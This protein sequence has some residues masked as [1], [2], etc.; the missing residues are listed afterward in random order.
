MIS[1]IVFLD[2]RKWFFDIKKSSFFISRIIFWYKKLF[3]DIKNRI[4]DIKK[5]FSDV[6]KYLK[7]IKTVPHTYLSCVCVFFGNIPGIFAESN[8]DFRYDDTRCWSEVMYT[9]VY[10]MVY[11]TR[12]AWT[13]ASFF[14]SDTWMMTLNFMYIHCIWQTKIELKK[15]NKFSRLWITL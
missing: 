11:T 9:M 10:T 1:N 14:S 13:T 3:F 7:N 6:R 12:V 8:T 2:I 4:F 5:S 15:D